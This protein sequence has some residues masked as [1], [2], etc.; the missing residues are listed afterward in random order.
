MPFSDAMNIILPPQ[1]TPHGDTVAS[2]VTGN[3]GEVRQNGTHGGTDFNYTGG[4]S[5]IN[6]EHPT[7]HSP[8]DGSVIFSGGQYGTIKIR[9]AD[10]VTHEILHTQSQSVAVG[11]RVS[12]GQAIGTMGGR[13]P[14]GA[15]QYARHV[16][17]QMRDAQGLPIN[18]QEW[19]AT[20]EP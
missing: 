1:N 11:D 7:V 20:R 9:G 2:H 19:W 8:V 10:G 3:Y 13:G 18:P 15:G 5:G 6:M 12:V 17:Y 14:N 4:Q 16:H